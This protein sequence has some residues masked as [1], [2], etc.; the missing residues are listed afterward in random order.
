[1]K[2]VNEVFLNGTDIKEV[3]KQIAEEFESK[4]K[5]TKISEKTK[6]TP[7]VYRYEVII[8]LPSSLEGFGIYLMPI[9]EAYPTFDFD[10]KFLIHVNPWIYSTEDAKEALKLMKKVRRLLPHAEVSFDDDPQ[11]FNSCIPEEVISWHNK[12]YKGEYQYYIDSYKAED[13]M[14]TL[15]ERGTDFED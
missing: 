3:A 13:I 5:R 9:S 15:K 12:M 8:K 6:F 11:M 4:S 14:E 10:G 1:M 2:K 7:A